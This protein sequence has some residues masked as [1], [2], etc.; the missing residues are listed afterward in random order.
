MV[1]SNVIR[2]S[3]ALTCSVFLVSAV[4]SQTV[5]AQE[6]TTAEPTHASSVTPY[7]TPG[8]SHVISA[9]GVGPGRANLQLRG[10]FY[11]QDRTFIGAPA[12]GSQI[13]TVSGGVALGLNQYVDVFGVL[14]IY[15]LRASTNDGSGFGSSVIGAQVGIPFSRETPLRVAVQAAGIFG[16]A[17]N[18]INSNGLDGYNYLETRTGNDFMVRIVQS[19]LM[20]NDKGVGFNIHLNEGVISSLQSGKD[21]S[22]I[23][24]AGV[25]IIPISSLIIGVEANSRTFLNDVVSSDP[26]WVTPS[27][28]WRTPAFVN[29]NV[30][31]DISLSK[32]RGIPARALEPWRIFGA[33]TYSIDTKA[34]EKRQAAAERKATLEKMRADSLQKASLSNQVL[35]AQQKNDSLSNAKAMS[36]A[37]AKA[38]ADSAAMKAHND[39]LALDQSNKLL[40]EERNKRSEMEKQLLTTGLLLLDAVYFETGKTQISINSEPYLSLIA[41]MLTKYP[42]LQIEIG[43]HTDNVG[44]LAYNQNLSQ[45]RAD[46]VV[47]YMLKEAPD[48][49]GRLTAKGYAYSQPKADNKTANGR[50]LNRRTELKVVNKDALKDYNP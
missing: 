47:A 15:N 30:G 6:K 3:S 20:T 13:T 40:M 14:N 37:R 34:G 42:K 48:L 2:R 28:T 39:S 5:V 35:T 9:E 43:G 29:I 22:L 26:L 19:L 32:D 7:A 27:I 4:L 17:G 16:T 11:Q 44:G 10:N 23:T 49:Q 46:A 12:S 21:I 50:Q 45:G 25:E 24:G 33:L 38:A 8:M 31:S 18:Q 1:F 41:K 36:D